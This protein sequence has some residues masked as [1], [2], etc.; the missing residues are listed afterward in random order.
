MH[1]GKSEY[2]YKPPRVLIAIENMTNE[3]IRMVLE[4]E[5]NPKEEQKGPARILFSAIKTANSTSY[6]III[7]E[8]GNGT[9]RISI[10]R[11]AT[12]RLPRGFVSAPPAPLLGYTKKLKEAYGIE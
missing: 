11:L 2:I 10:E 7:Y 6:R 9:R 1:Y 5:Y 4:N 8:L 12:K 3:K